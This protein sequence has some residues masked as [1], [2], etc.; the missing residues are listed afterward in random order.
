MIFPRLS[1]VV[2][3]SFDFLPR[4]CVLE[5]QTVA[6][7]YTIGMAVTEILAQQVWVSLLGMN[8]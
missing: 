6:F 2:S 7:L 4:R 8:L 1:S 5:T 3:F